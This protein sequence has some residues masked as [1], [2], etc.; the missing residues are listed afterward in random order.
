MT[1]ILLPVILLT[2]LSITFTIKT[3][4]LLANVDATNLDLA[5]QLSDSYVAAHGTFIQKNNGNQ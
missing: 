4:H 3:T 2:L 1:K 5:V